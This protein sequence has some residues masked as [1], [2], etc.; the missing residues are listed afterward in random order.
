MTNPT[1]KV[2]IPDNRQYVISPSI[3]D[4][5]HIVTY[6][7]DRKMG[8]SLQGLILA[9]LITMILGATCTSMAS[10]DTDEGKFFYITGIVCS[11]IGLSGA[12]SSIVLMIKDG[13]S[14]KNETNYH[15]QGEIKKANSETVDM[16]NVEESRGEGESNS[17]ISI[18]E[19]L[20]AR[21]TLS[22]EN[23]IRDEESQDK[24]DSSGFQYCT[25]L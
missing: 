5:T 10:S 1:N 23:L 22:N 14:K 4:F 18:A 20:D 25:L 16:G 3:Y 21:M 2:I 11:I 8:K 6:I 17:N 7:K 19:Q 13:C 15:Y 24:K 9:S 12:I